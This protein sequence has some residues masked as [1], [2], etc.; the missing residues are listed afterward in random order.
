MVVPSGPGA[1]KAIKL[2]YRQGPGRASEAGGVRLR[3]SAPLP[4][5]PG[6]P[7]PLAHPALVS[8]VFPS[9]I[10]LPRSGVLRNHG[11]GTGSRAF[12]GP[13]LNQRTQRPELGKPQTVP[14]SGGSFH[15]IRLSFMSLSG[16]LTQWQ[17]QLEPLMDPVAPVVPRSLSQGGEGTPQAHR[18][19]CSQQGPLK[20][21][22]HVVATRVGAGVWREP[23]CSRRNSALQ[24][25][26]RPALGTSG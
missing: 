23:T 24:L 11:G 7:R 2:S 9:S 10:R 4:P 14:S 15:S 16:S 25:P 18:S 19:S 6:P 20:P 22:G 13:F 8:Y 12:Y 5:C 3:P 17:G 21:A 1:R 26:R